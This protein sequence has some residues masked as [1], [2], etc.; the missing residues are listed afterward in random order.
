LV[1][2]YPLRYSKNKKPQALSTAVSGK[3]KP[4]KTAGPGSGPRFELILYFS[5]VYVRHASTRKLRHHQYPAT[6]NLL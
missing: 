1:L 2:I 5:V 4:K 3:E 6:S